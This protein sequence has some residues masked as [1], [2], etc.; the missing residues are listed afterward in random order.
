MDKKPKFKYNKLRGL[1]REHYGTQAVF[2][3]QLGLGTTTLTSRLNGD[4]YF[5]QAE[6]LKASKLLRIDNQAERDA[7]FF[8]EQIR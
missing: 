5:D 1:I 4:S 7:I 3:E 8:E 2:A 6:I